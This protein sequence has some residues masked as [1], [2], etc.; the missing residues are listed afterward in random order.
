MI[1]VV[2][3]RMFGESVHA[4][5]PPKARASLS[6]REESFGLSSA[7]SWSMSAPIRSLVGTAPEVFS[8]LYGTL[9]ETV[10]R[11]LSDSDPTRG[12]WSSVKDLRDVSGV[13]EEVMARVFPVSR[14][15]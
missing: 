10:V 5:A 13:S 12:T 7:E 4:T 8:D 6:A 3:G 9:G 1:V 2:R 11:E 15:G 14:R